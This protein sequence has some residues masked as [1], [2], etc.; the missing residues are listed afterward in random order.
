MTW[1]QAIKELADNGFTAIFPNMLWGG[2]AFYQSDVLPVAP[3]V[4]T[5]GDQIAQ[6]PRPPAEST[7]SSAMCGR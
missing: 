6:C 1:D 4:A 5:R 3:E 2:S 7:A